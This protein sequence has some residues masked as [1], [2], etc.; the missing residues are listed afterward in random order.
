MFGVM[1]SSKIVD[2]ILWSSSS[3]ISPPPNILRQK[4]VWRHQQYL[5]DLLSHSTIEGL[6]TDA[7]K[8]GINDKVNIF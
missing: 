4:I 7:Q 8:N 1:R 2:Y 6:L 5:E 3:T